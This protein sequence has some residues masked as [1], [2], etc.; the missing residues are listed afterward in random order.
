MMKSVVN[1]TTNCTM[2]MKLKAKSSKYL[3]YYIFLILNSVLLMGVEYLK[4]NPLLVEELY[5]KKFYPLWTYIYVILFSWVP[6]SVGDVFYGI[7]VGGIVFLLLKIIASSL[8]KKIAHIKRYSLLLGCIL[9]ALYNIFYINWGLHYFRVPVVEKIG[10][11]IKNITESQYEQ[12]LFT[13]IERIN[14]LRDSLDLSTKHIQGVKGDIAEFIQQGTMFDSF[15]SESQIHIKAPISSELVSYFTVSGY[16]NPFTLEAHVNQSM[17]LAS[18]PFV[19]VHELAHQMGIGFEDECNFIAFTKLYNH[20]NLWYRYAAYY[21]A[22]E[23]LI[24]LYRNDPE[25]MDKIRAKLSPKVL[26]DYK[27]ERAFWL[28]Y[29]SKFDD[30]TNWFY[31]HFLVHNNQPEGLMRYSMMSRLVVAWELEQTHTGI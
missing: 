17:P 22:I 29:R 19:V 31:N 6:F 13:Y 24:A 23:Y 3:Y 18:Y 12:V 21:S 15:L 14:L 4:S 27:E 26:A 30:V 5:A 8:N 11:D 7:C 28:G 1:R 16:F 25:K 10:L 9:L 20:K 2:K